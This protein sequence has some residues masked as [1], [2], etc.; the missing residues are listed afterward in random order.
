MKVI[1]RVFRMRCESNSEASDYVTCSIEKIRQ[2]IERELSDL[3]EKR[4]KAKLLGLA[5]CGKTS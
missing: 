4:Y 1:G 2:L 3:W 5:V